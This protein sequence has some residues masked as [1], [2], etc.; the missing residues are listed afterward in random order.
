[1]PTRRKQLV[2]IALACIVSI[3]IEL[4]FDSTSSF[5]RIYSPADE[6]K[7]VGLGSL[8]KAKLDEAANQAQESGSA[9]RSAPVIK[10]SGKSA[11]NFSFASHCAAPQLAPAL[12]P[13]V[14]VSWVRAKIFREP[15]EPEAWVRLRPPIC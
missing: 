4:T 12:R 15:C 14:E 3:V 13:F 8:L 7:Q 11:S 2:W 9:G 5:I 6:A 1:M 10:T